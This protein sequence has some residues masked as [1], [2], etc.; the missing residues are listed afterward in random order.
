[1]PLLDYYIIANG[2]IINDSLKTIYSTDFREYGATD[3]YRAFSI[4]NEVTGFSVYKN[5]VLYRVRIAP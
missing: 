3:H 1:M 4:I 2:I 5:G